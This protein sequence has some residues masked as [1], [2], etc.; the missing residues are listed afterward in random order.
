M[1]RYS[2]TYPVTTPFT[3]RYAPGLQKQGGPGLR[4][5]LLFELDS[6]SSEKNACLVTLWSKIYLFLHWQSAPYP[7]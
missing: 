4:I 2:L 6:V 7:S 1:V 3:T 5:F